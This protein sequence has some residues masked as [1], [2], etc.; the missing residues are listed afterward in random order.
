MKIL[1]TKSV[2]KKKQ[3]SDGLRVCIM[4]RPKLEEI[5]FDIL[6]PSLAPT[7]ELLDRYKYHDLGWK[8]FNKEFSKYMANSA[9]VKRDLT[10]L[11]YLVENHSKV[12]LL[13]WEIDHQECH[14][15]LIAKTIK[16]LNPEI[17]LEHN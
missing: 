14:R 2:Q 15:S 3:T 4:R 9:E 6:L 10:L 13:C 11:L 7:N 8:Q 17:M 16:E 12:T 1:A 5:D